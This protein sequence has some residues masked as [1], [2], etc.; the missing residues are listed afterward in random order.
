VGFCHLQCAHCSLFALWAFVIC[1]VRTVRCLLGPLLTFAAMSPTN[2]M[3]EC[4]MYVAQLCL[5]ANTCVQ[6][7]CAH[8]ITQCADTRTTKRPCW[9][10]TSMP[11]KRISR[12]WLYRGFHELLVARTWTTDTIDTA[13]TWYTAVRRVRYR[14]T[15]CAVVRVLT[16]QFVP[17]HR[18][19]LRQARTRVRVQRKPRATMRD[20][21]VVGL[22]K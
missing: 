8:K 20:Q 9:E 22:Q 18:T 11:Q 2:N 17:S 16:F 6:F 13:C 1:N 12:A 7:G 15:H 14:M 3:G 19:A 21:P 10:S 4:T 5:T